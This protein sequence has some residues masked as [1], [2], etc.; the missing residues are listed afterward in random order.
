MQEGTQRE[1]TLKELE[2]EV[3]RELGIQNI[4][5][6][7]STHDA[8]RLGGYMVKKLIERGEKAEGQNR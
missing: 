7:M 2:E 8:G 3:K 4:G 5:P 6:N 1:Q